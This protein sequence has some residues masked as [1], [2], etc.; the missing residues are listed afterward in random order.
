MKKTIEDVMVHNVKVQ[1]ELKNVG[2]H[3]K[4]SKVQLGLQMPIIM[5]FVFNESKQ[6][7][8][9]IKQYSKN[10][11]VLYLD[12][13]ET[14]SITESIIKYAMLVAKEMDSKALIIKTLLG[15][16]DK[17]IPAT[18]FNSSSLIYDSFTTNKQKEISLFYINIETNYIEKVHY[19]IDIVTNTLKQIKKDVVTF[20]YDLY[21]FA[22]YLTINYYYKGMKSEHG[23][24]LHFQDVISLNVEELSISKVVNSS[25][26]LRGLIYEVFEE[27]GEETKFSRLIN[28][29]KEH[30]SNYLFYEFNDN[31]LVDMTFS[32][33]MEDIEPELIENMFATQADEV[34]TLIDNSL[35]YLFYR[36]GAY[37]FV[38]NTKAKTLNKFYNLDDANNN[39]KQ[40]VQK[41]MHLKYL[42][43]V[44]A[45]EEK[46][47]TNLKNKQA[48][49]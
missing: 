2:K 48:V 15:V 40:I 44:Q 12:T 25:K 45:F 41:E 43:S 37:Y 24:S 17:E 7:D 38:M 16:N 4:N 27:I 34:F 1:E 47:E 31:K 33:L 19:Y 10:E 36:I 18:K 42:A 26:D 13:H 8:F 30:F 6:I 28:P 49:E 11:T 39:Y 20:K 23:M 9:S 14:P 5:V 3:L 21:K 32:S 46:L 29:P 22:D 35:N